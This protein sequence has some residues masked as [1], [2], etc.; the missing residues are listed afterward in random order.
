MNNNLG[1]MKLV[2]LLIMNYKVSD[3]RQTKEEVVLVSLEVCRI[4]KLL[5]GQLIT[6]LISLQEV[7]MVL[8]M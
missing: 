5:H 3:G 6:S 8:R 7:T 2:Q 4:P 1:S